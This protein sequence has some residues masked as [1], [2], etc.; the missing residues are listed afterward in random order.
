M[1]QRQEE[2]FSPHGLTARQW[3]QKVLRGQ[4][5]PVREISDIVKWDSAKSEGL[6]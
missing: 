3:F 2:T 6:F 1:N 4:P 5:Q